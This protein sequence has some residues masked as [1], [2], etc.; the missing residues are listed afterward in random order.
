M[1]QSVVKQQRHRLKKRYFDGVP[2]NEIRTTSP[3]PS[4]S[5]EQWRALVAKCLDPK[6]MVNICCQI[7]FFQNSVHKFSYFE[8]MTSCRNHVKRT[9]RIAIE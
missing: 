4:I 3:V 2:A 5:D 8:P 6:N 7:F 1:L 9:S